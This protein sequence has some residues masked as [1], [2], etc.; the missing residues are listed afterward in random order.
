[1]QLTEE[2][3]LWIERLAAISNRYPETPP[4][5][6]SM[7]RL[8]ELGYA[9]VGRTGRLAITAKG[10]AAWNDRTGGD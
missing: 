5:A 4:P 10:R 1:M 3:W 2:D 8:V 9:K 7:D 6:D